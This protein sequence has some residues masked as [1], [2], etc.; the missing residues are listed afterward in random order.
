VERDGTIRQ[1]EQALAKLSV[2]EVPDAGALAKRGE[3]YFSYA[4]SSAVRP[5][6]AQVYQGK[7]EASNF[8]PVE[9]AIGVVQ[10]MRQFEMLQRAITLGSELNRRSIEEVGKV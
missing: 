2:V 5:G 8:S 6:Q 3:T 4:S 7:L 9:S 1:Q 10:V